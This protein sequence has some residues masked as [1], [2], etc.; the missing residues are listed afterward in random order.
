[1][2]IKK[3]LGQYALALPSLFL[4]FASVQ[5]LKGRSI[6]Y[7]LEFGFIW[8][9]VSLVIFAARRVYMYKKNIECAVCNDIQQPR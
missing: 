5:Y 6:E 7:A 2:P 1:M 9:V 3:W 8:S 4:L